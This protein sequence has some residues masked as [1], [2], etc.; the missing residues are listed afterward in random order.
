[1]AQPPASESAAQTINGER[2]RMFMSC[3]PEAQRV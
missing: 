2:L 3:S 1:L